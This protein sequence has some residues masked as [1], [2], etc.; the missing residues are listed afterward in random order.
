MNR[1]IFAMQE[2][3]GKRPRGE[4][5]VEIIEMLSVALLH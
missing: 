4:K 2:I 5:K 3:V 1:R